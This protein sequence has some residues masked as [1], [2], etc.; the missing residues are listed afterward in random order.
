VLFRQLR[1]FPS[2]ASANLVGAEGW[3]VT[4]SGRWPS[5]VWRDDDR[6]LF[7]VNRGAG[8]GRY[9]TDLDSAGDQDGVYV[10]ATNTVHMLA[11]L[12]GFVGYE[13]W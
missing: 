7:Q 6:I 11:T 10:A 12:S 1:G 4:A 2:N 13:H 9:I 8:I 5:P 3:G